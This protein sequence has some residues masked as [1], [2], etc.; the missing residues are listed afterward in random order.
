MNLSTAVKISLILSFWTIIFF[1]YMPRACTTEL[2][3]Q[4][5]LNASYAYEAQLAARL[6]DHE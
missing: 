2:A 4:D 1:V 5:G 3:S 6:N